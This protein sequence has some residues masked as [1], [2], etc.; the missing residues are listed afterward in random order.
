MA[1]PVLRLAAGPLADGRLPIRW[2]A[3]MRHI[4]NDP[5][6]VREVIS[7]RTGGGGRVPLGWMRTFLESAPLVEPEQFLG[8]PVLMVHPGD[9][10]WT[11]LSVSRPFFDRI[12]AEKSLVILENCGHFPVEQPGFTRLLD[13]VGQLVDDVRRPDPS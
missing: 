9:D 13:A 5:G 2:V 8:P 6:L 4:A 3:D 10:R 1:G 7:D 11:P 12:G